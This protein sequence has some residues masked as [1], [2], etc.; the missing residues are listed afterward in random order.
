MPSQVLAY[1]ADD[2]INEFASVKKDSPVTVVARCIGKRK[3][4][5]PGG[6]SVILEHARM[7]K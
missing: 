6:Y 7:A 4:E 3:S 2:A 1:L 5:T